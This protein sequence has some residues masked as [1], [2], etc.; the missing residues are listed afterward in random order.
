[1]YLSYSNSACS[2]W[3]K[4]FMRS[5]LVCWPTVCKLMYVLYCCNGLLYVQYMYTMIRILFS[6]CNQQCTGLRTLC[7]VQCTVHTL[8]QCIGWVHRSMYIV[9]WPL[10]IENWYHLYLTVLFEIEHCALACFLHCCILPVQSTL[11]GSVQLGTGRCGAK[12]GTLKNN[13]NIA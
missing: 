5:A 6:S 3:L 7:I 12:G 2:Y 11:S 10:Y 1:M 8:C 4:E 13:F 9:H